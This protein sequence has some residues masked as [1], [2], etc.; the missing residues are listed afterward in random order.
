MQRIGAG[1]PVLM[2][3][4]L[5]LSSRIWGGFAEAL[6]REFEV[7]L[8]DLRGHGRS[9]WDGSPFSIADMADD[10]EALLDQ[11]DVPRVGVV[12]MSMGGSVALVLAASQSHRIGSMVVADTTAWYGASRVVDWNKRAEDALQSPRT[13]LLDFQIPRWFTE[14]FRE[15]C[16]EI[17]DD[18][19]A[20]FLATDPR[21]HAFA[22]KALGG[23]DARPLLSTITAPTLVMVGAEDY[24]TPPSMA[25]ALAA[26]IP[27][28][29][30]QIVDRV[31][32][33][34]L[35]ESDGLAENAAI[36]LRHHLERVT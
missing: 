3:H 30:L 7:W 13:A 10:V 8:I 5:A 12:G 19:C 21:L 22:C 25:R 6:A 32:H 36:H 34:S 4:P 9:G 1:R 15:Q 24:A 33:L 27:A 18:I 35:V 20:E 14:S 11:A 28:A 26:A 31:R 2:L 29:E 16:P 17:V 23:L